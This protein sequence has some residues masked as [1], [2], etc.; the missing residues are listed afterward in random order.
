MAFL[1]A[2]PVSQSGR[3]VL[4]PGEVER[5]LVEGVDLTV[6]SLASG[7]S[8]VS[9][10]ALPRVIG[11]AHLTTHRL[12]WLATPKST[13]NPQGGAL[14]SLHCALP[15]GALADV[16]HARKGLGAVFYDPKLRLRV[17]VTQQ[18]TASITGAKDAVGNAGIALSF[19]AGRYDDFCQQLQEALNQKVW[20]NDPPPPPAP[21]STP[22]TSV[23]TDSASPSVPLGHRAPVAFGT[24]RAGISGILRHEQLASAQTTRTLETAFTDLDALMTKA[25]DLVKLADRMRAALGSQQGTSS[26]TQGEQEEIQEWF[27]S[28]GIASPVTKETAGALYH[29]QLS[30]QLADFL[31]VPLERAGG[32]IALPDV[33]CMFNRARGTELISPED[34]VQACRVWESINVHLRL[35]KF[36][37]GVLVVQSKTHNDRQAAEQLQALVRPSGGRE[38]ISISDAAKALGVAPALAREQLLMA[39]SYGLLC[40]DESAD[41]LRFH[42][43]FFK[44][45]QVATAFS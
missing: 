32:M 4:L 18:G 7:T 14:T 43:N 31:L 33:Y 36:D 2:L 37:S 38:G 23:P 12:L 30:R 17:W 34:L 25:R 19:R 41:G 5:I 28:V 9:Q 39:E 26:E 16:F 11:V 40:R 35:R 27:L 21:T 6:E 24:S 45:L 8:G 20:L 13:N 22:S 3:P 1:T 10:P 42:D 29:Q 44:A 15:L